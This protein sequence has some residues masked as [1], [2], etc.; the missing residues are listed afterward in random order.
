MRSETMRIRNWLAAAFAVVLMAGGAN[1]SLIPEGS[2]ESCTVV[3]LPGNG[4]SNSNC[5]WTFSNFA[6]VIGSGGNPGK[7]VRLETNGLDTLDPTAERIVGGL[8]IGQTYRI[9]WDRVVRQAVGGAGA[10][11]SFGVFLDTQDFA[12]ALFLLAAG[13]VNG[14]Y[15]SEFAEFT[16][17]ATT[18]TFIFAG[19]LDGRS[20]GAGTTDVSHNFD[21][22]CLDIVGGDCGG[23]ATTLAAPDAAATLAG[24]LALLTLLGLRRR[25]ALRL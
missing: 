14:S 18:H 2:F 7:A 21:N 15:F 3:G 10:G 20:N 23:V 11:P 1:A 16:A 4:A 13:T 5:G 6:G 22:V 24:G 12:S 8:T 19:E 17:T 25:T 9:A